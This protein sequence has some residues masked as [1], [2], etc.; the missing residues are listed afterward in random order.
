MV[1]RETTRT[2][3][4]RV[5]LIEVNKEVEEDHRVEDTADRTSNGLAKRLNTQRRIM[6]R[7]L[8]RISKCLI[9][10]MMT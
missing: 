7:T 8:S 9:L 4:A 5:K 10:A 2:K 3:E 1:S 6:L